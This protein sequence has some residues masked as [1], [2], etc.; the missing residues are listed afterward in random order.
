LIGFNK[1]N[2]S[3]KFRYFVD[4]L[5]LKRERLLSMPVLLTE[6]PDSFAKKMR[7]FK[8]GILDNK[9]LDIFDLDMYANF[10]LASPA[11]LLA[12]KKYCI[13]YKIN[14]KSSLNVLRYT[15]KKLMR[16]I[17]KNITKEEAMK[18]GAK[19][20]FPFKQRYDRWMKEYRLWSGG[21]FSRRDRRII[22][23]L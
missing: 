21:F 4:F 18:K 8:L 23:R 5:E 12:K 6:N 15:W 20:T 13:E 10:Y 16:K 9:R 19:L 7:M 22:L 1:D 3:R 17:D 2:L 14:F 11:T